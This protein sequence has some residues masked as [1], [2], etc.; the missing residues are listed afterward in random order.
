MF[1]CSFFEMPSSAVVCFRELNG[2]EI[3]TSPRSR[4]K[5]SPLLKLDQLR[6]T[7]VALT[8]RRPLMCSSRLAEM[9]LVTTWWKPEATPPVWGTEETVSS[10]ASQRLSTLHPLSAVFCT[11]SHSTLTELARHREAH[12]TTL[13]QTVMI[14]L[15]GHIWT[16]EWIQ[17]TLN[18]CQLKWNSLLEKWWG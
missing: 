11:M 5:Q 18:T 12:G 4:M 15:G 8:T 1:Y 14:L 13:E 16:H 3:L 17:M 7:C 2:Q 9:S 10:K 6:G